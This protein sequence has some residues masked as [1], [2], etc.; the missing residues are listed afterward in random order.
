M[1]EPESATSATDATAT[2]GA[3]HGPEA[4]ALALASLI[5]ASRRD[6]R[7]FAQ[8][9][10]PAVFN[11][12]AMTGAISQFATQHPRNRLRLLIEDRSDLLR[13]NGRLLD[14]ARRLADA[15]ELREVDDNDRGARDLF[16][17]ADRSASLVQEDIGRADAVVDRQ[18]VEA[19][20]LIER[21]DAAWERGASIA[22][23]TL[24]L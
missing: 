12:A 8:R 10:N 6:V 19:L 15:V 3:I 20:K 4:L 5:G 7:I 14:L 24:G 9:L 22:L 17:V 23:R 16:L 18:A 21:F 13:D 11:S 2:T 1:T